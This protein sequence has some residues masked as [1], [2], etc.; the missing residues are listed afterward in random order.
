MRHQGHALSSKSIRKAENLD[1]PLLA[2]RE[3]Q[4]I[5]EEL[6]R[7]E[8][9]HIESARAKG[10]S[11]EDVAEALGITRQALQQRMKARGSSQGEIRLPG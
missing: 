7:L 5:R 3:I 9:A 1:L 10:A 11:W 2:L 6:D 4:E 8:I